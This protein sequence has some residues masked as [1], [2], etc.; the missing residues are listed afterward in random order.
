MSIVHL[1]C[2]FLLIREYCLVKMIALY[3]SNCFHS[4]VVS[5]QKGDKYCLLRV[6]S[7]EGDYPSLKLEDATQMEQK[8][9]SNCAA[10]Y[11]K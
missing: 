1:V 7:L 9:F 11:W 3:G 8:Y 10:L 2:E 4:R 5:Y 6:A